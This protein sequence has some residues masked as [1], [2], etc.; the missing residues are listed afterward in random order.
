MSY[1]FDLAFMGCLVSTMGEAGVVNTITGYLLAYS[2]PTRKI[3]QDE[4]LDA[5]GVYIFHRYP[6]IHYVGKTS[7]SFRQRFLER[8]HSPS[9]SDQR[10]WSLI[11]E[12]KDYYVL[13]PTHFPAQLE[14]ILLAH[15][16]RGPQQNLELV[17]L[18]DFRQQKSLLW[19]LISYPWQTLPSLFHN[20]TRILSYV[21]S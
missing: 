8:R 1:K 10:V 9:T 16:F 5:K 18:E 3:L 4:N 19:E 20:V 17:A 14:S 11:K 6:E 2:Q 13:I 12:E 15:D 21:W 7:R